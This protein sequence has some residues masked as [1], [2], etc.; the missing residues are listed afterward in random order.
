VLLVFCQQ[1]QW[2]TGIFLGRHDLCFLSKASSLY[3]T[4]QD[5]CL[6]DRR[7]LRI[8]G[9]RGPTRAL[10]FLVKRYVCTSSPLELVSTK[11]S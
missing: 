7:S 9:V 4:V 3:G 10:L 5:V 11:A 8:N 1:R 2:S 6:A